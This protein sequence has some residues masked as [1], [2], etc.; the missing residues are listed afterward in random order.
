VH[1]SIKS[2]VVKISAGGRII[3]DSRRRGMQ[4]RSI[5]TGAGGPGGGLKAVIRLTA[6]TTSR[7]VGSKNV[8]SRSG[9]RP[10]R[11]PRV[12]G[13]AALFV[14]PRAPERESPWGHSEREHNLLT[15]QVA[16]NAALSKRA[17]TPKE[18]WSDFD[19]AIP[20]FE[21]RRPSQQVRFL[22]HI[23]GTQEDARP[24]RRLARGR[25]VTGARCTRSFIPS[26]AYR[27]GV[28]ARDLQY[29]HRKHRRLGSD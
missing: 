18:K 25:A 26:D 4:T 14:G 6:A 3:C 24:F 28:S 23:G 19:S 17:L 2:V 22:S 9:G 29:P 16:D 27:T 8:A 12:A 20:W 13:A 11:R 7:C 10:A 15:P 21:S 1:S 5:R